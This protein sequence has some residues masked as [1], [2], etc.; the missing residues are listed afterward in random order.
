MPIFY[1]VIL[2]LWTDI[3]YFCKWLPTF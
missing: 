1:I 2:W 3:V